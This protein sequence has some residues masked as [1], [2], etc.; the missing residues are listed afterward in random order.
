MCQLPLLNLPILLE[1]SQLKQML[2]VMATQLVLLQLPQILVLE[3]LPIY[4]LLMVVQPRKHR[5]HFR[6]FQ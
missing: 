2:I 4:T 5:E 3:Q 1:L 6:V